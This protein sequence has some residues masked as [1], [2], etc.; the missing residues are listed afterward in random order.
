MG[1]SIEKRREEILS[2]VNKDGTLDFAQLRKAFPDISDVTLRKDM[3]YLDDSQQAI[4]T[5]GG[6]KS[7]PSA[8]NYYYRSN[9]NR[10]LK[11][12]IAIKAAGLIRPGD[13]IF[14]SA[15][16]TCAEMARYLPVFPLKVCSDG[17]YTVS[18]IS[19][20]PNMSV[21]L[22]GGDVDLNIMRV[23]GISALNYL[24]SCHFTMAFVGALSVNPDYGFAHNSAM[25][26]AILAKV[27]QHSDRTAV[28][29]DSTKVTDSFSPYTIPFSSVDMLVTD[30]ELP[31]EKAELL[32]AK[33]IA[34]I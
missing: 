19:M 14:L 9:V 6:I 32:R 5:H 30:D 28:L 21:Q 25:T 29:A 26:T 18:N 2:L 17:V 22:I 15:G 16:T 23:E 7:I 34:V 8:L 12:A 27:I 24:D 11:K 13:S 10:G 31:P 4:R 3:Q 33:G 1:K 20:L